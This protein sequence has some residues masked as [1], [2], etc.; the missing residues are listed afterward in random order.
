MQIPHGQDATTVARR[1]LIRMANDGK[2]LGATNAGY[3]H[4]FAVVRQALC[5][6]D[7]IQGLVNFKKK[8][9]WNRSTNEINYDYNLACVLNGYSNQATAAN[10]IF[11][12]EERMKMFLSITDDNGNLKEHK[13]DSFGREIFPQTTQII[14]NHLIP[15]IGKVGAD[16]PLIEQ[17]QIDEIRKYFA[18]DGYSIET[19]AARYGDVKARYQEYKPQFI[20][21]LNEGL[22]IHVCANPSHHYNVF[23][24]GNKFVVTG[25]GEPAFYNHL[26]EAICHFGKGALTY[27]V[28]TVP[29]KQPIYGWVQ[30]FKTYDVQKEVFA[31]KTFGYRPWVHGRIKVGE[32]L[33]PPEKTMLLDNYIQQIKQ[34]NWNKQVAWNNFLNHQKFNNQYMMNVCCNNWHYNNNLG[35]IAFNNACKVVN[36]NPILMAYY[37]R[38]MNG[39]IK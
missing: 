19:N 39:M 25:C 27:T 18:S 11:N 6:P 28:Y 21:S 14:K 34:A 31:Y 1:N 29:K 35:I 17:C 23:R 4:W 12:V 10:A 20:A 13:Y 15:S 3:C 9:Y 16:D 24:D 26:S 37:N 36:N 5:N 38:K 7:F 22:P 8:N 32:K 33:L 2:Y 30:G